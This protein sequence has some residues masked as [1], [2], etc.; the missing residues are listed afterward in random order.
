MKTIVVPVDFSTISLNAANYAADMSCVL[1]TNLALLYVCP[2]PVILSE[3]PVQPISMEEMIANGEKEISA[4]KEKLEARVGDRIKIFTQ[5]EEGDTVAGIDA[6][7]KSIRPYAVVMGSESLGAIERALMGGKTIDAM[8]KLHWP[9]LVI[10]PNVKFASI[11]KIGLAC[12]FRKVVETIP[13]KEIKN[14][15]R[16][17]NAELHVLHVSHHPGDTFSAQTIEES[18]WVAEMLGELNPK[19]D[20]IRDSDIEKGIADFAEKNNLD[21][22]ITIPKKHSLASQLFQHS[23]STR[24]VL[25][26][27]VPVL[28]IHE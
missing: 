4:L 27:H 8:K 6:Y 26:T 20:F 19:Y 7:C 12:D 25:H 1:G 22:L 13:V 10:P 14:L 21:L 16:E 11:R 17:F 5:V 2:L 15:V 28:A 9:L 3:V 24:L 18:E 23:H